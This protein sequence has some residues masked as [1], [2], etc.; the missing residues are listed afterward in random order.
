L[1][2]CVCDDDPTDKKYSEEA[3][4]SLRLMRLSMA[5]RRLEVA[6]ADLEEDP[7]LLLATPPPLEELFLL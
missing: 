4:E 2:C 6:A 7:R 5:A 1:T 3:V